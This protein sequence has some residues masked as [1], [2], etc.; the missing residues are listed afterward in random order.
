MRALV[1]LV[2]LPAVLAF[3]NPGRASAEPYDQYLDRLREICSVECLQPRQFLRAARKRDAEEGGDMAIIMDVA[4][5]RRNGSKFEL[6]NLDTQ[7]SALEELA[8]LGSAGVN[9]SSRSG[10]GGLPR[11]QQTGR[12]PNVLAIEIGDQTLF[13]ILNAVAP[14][15]QLTGGR[16]DQDGIVVDGERDRE[17]VEPTL[18]ELRAFFRNRRVVVRGRPRLEV[19][20]V[21]ARRDFRRK[22]VTLE[23]ANGDHIA[24]LPRFGRDGE[25]NLSE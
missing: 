10:V 14:D 15:G 13:D 4:E 18:T 2:S 12:H 6:Y 25:P 23:L 17:F 11:G 16:G 1:M 20:T 21:G 19:A 9:T 24:L 3:T 22:Q 7:A 5:V 8:I